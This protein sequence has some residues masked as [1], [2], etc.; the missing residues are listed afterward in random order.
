MIDDECIYATYQVECN[1][2]LVTLRER[3]AKPWVD[4]QRHQWSIPRHGAY[5]KNIKSSLVYSL[6]ARICAA[7]FW[8]M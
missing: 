7:D 6:G 4:A 2:R 5:R 8:L 3:E 1:E